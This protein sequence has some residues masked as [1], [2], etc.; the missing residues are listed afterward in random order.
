MEKINKSEIIED[1][2]RLLKIALK[3]VEKTHVKIVET[4]NSINKIPGFKELVENDISELINMYEEREGIIA[5]EPIVIIP[6][7]TT[8][9]WLYLKKDKISHNYF[10]R[11]KNYLIEHESL[12]ENMVNQI[13]SDSQRIL[14]YCS[15]PD[16]IETNKINR[17]K[18]LVVG[19]VQSGKTSN[20]LGLIA[21][22]CDYGYKVI[23]LLS[24]LTDNL[25]VQTQKRIDKAFVGA[26]SNTIGSATDYVGVGQNSK[27]Y[28]AIPLTNVDSDFGKSTQNVMNFTF[29]NFSKP[30]ILV[31][32]KNKAVLTALKDWL[33]PGEN[34]ID[35]KI[36]IID[37]EAD[38]A[39]LN[40]RKPNPNNEPSAINGLIRDIF[41]NF[42]IAS[43]VGY[44][45]TPFANVFINPDDDDSYRDLFP[46]DFI[47][48]LIAPKTYFGGEK[49]FSFLDNAI[50]RPIRILNPFEESFL[51]EDHKN[52]EKFEI[53]PFSL[54]EAILSFLINNAIRTLRGDV[55]KHRSMLINISRFN[56]VQADIHYKVSEY[57]EEIRRTF[58]QSHYLPD[59]KFLRNQDM[60]LLRDIYFESSFY[61]Q[62]SKTYSWTDV[63]KTMNAELKMFRVELM[64]SRFIKENRFD[65]DLLPD[66]A[67]VIVIGGFI[68]SRGLTLEGLCVSYFSRAANAYDTML[69]MCRWFGYR[70]N[71][72]DLCRV[73]I[74]QENLDNFR[75]VLEAVEDLKQQFNEMQLKDKSPDEYGLMVRESPDTLETTMLITAR[76]KMRDGKEIL[77]YL[78]YGGV[79]VDTS[80][81]F[82]Q[83]NIINENIINTQKFLK[84][85]EINLTESNQSQFYEN[86][87]NNQI[88]D[89]L[90]SL[91]YPLEN[92]RFAKESL[93]A[94][95]KQTNVFNKW[96]VVIASGDG[97]SSD[98][99]TSKFK[100]KNTIRRF[101]VKPN[102]NYIRV[103]GNKNRI[104]DPGIFKTGLNQTQLDKVKEITN[105]RVQKNKDKGI[106]NSKDTTASDYLALKEIHPL[107]VIYPIQLNKPE[108]SSDSKIEKVNDVYLEEFYKINKSN[109]FIGVALGFPSRE[110]KTIIKYLANIRMIDQIYKDD[111]DEEGD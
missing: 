34:K 39:S 110:G 63:K 108:R 107:L 19:D 76:Q 37:D 24:G 23:V 105:S 104:L 65:Y 55:K 27:E 36:L 106:I 44:T 30:T 48:Q 47:I 70:P 85:I 83:E 71:Y 86:I 54:K 100:Y 21:T 35:D 6:K 43:Y 73:Y 62:I 91:K 29:G 111:S 42:K 13:E 75:A 8:N 11:Y 5:P 52:F 93:V 95:L 82:H 10:N 69:Q 60:K 1:A 49:V 15:N 20:Y 78:N 84:S 41:N 68:L 45:A 31:V 50:P 92:K 109:L 18:G 53:I 96:R 94:Y 40:I 57:V 81:I 28:Y 17:K 58:E 102:E 9:Q 97:N 2:Y 98:F 32:K 46:S 89:Y 59:E 90:E 66:G 88:A 74:T 99:L 77:K 38:N 4:A 16:D 25:R 33:K 87:S 7:G 3:N 26:K 14:S 56:D 22:A 64:N 72:E 12:N 67:R 79:V 51:K 80:K 103:S 101:E 61:D